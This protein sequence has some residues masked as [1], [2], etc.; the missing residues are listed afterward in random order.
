MRILGGTGVALWPSLLLSCGAVCGGAAVPVPYLYTE[1]AQ[2]QPDAADSGSERFPGGA[3]LQF[4]SNG[5]QRALAPGFAASADAAISF[6]GQRVLFSGKRK[7][8]DPWQ[9]WE[10][11]VAGGAA[12]LITSVREDSITPFYLPGDKIVYARRTPL[13]FQLET[14]PLDGGSPQRL[15][16][17]PGDHLACDVLRDGRVLFE[18]PHP[19]GAP[20]PLRDLY[21]VYADGS[22]VETF[23]CDHGRDRHAGREMSSG[24]VVFE[25]RGR[26]ARFTSP[27]AVEIELPLLEGKFAG[28]VAEISVEDWLVSFRP[29]SGVSYALYRFRPGQNAPENCLAVKAAHAVQP[30]LV[31]ARPVPKR[32]PSGLGNRE[33]ANVLCLNAY[34]SRLRI[35]EGSIAAVRVWELDDANLSAALGQA[36]VEQDGSFF[37]QV[38]SERPIRFELL[39]RNGGI[40]AAEKGWFW[41]RRGEQRVCAGCHAGPERAPENATPQVLLRTTEPVK[42]I[43]PLQSSSGGAK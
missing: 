12:R 1:A 20:S 42:M 4:V 16:Y 5:R 7:S 34:T 9:I 8:S 26:L 17:T 40:V 15:T 21:T 37:V 38:P 25:T 31:R 23:R 27:R 3:A 10:L 36:P 22:G 39:D 32:H 11:S 28:P 6:D 35:R 18:A 24:D 19:S 41:L 2:Y 29:N 33:G 13:G 43:F 30:V 14:M